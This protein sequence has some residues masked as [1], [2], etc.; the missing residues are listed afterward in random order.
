MFNESETLVLLRYIEK[1]RK[2]KSSQ[3]EHDL[4]LD[5]ETGV[6]MTRAEELRLRV[7][8]DLLDEFPGIYGDLH[9]PQGRLTLISLD[10]VSVTVFAP[11]HP[12]R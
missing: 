12:Y 9:T 3:E 5:I 4:I 6:D 11:L 8:N 10:R 2:L 7:A 1:A